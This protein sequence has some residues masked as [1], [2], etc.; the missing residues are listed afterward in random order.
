MIQTQRPAQVAVEPCVSRS[1]RGGRAA[2]IAKQAATIDLTLFQAGTG[3]RISEAL[4]IQKDLVAVVDGQ[5]FIN[6]TKEIAKTGV[7]RQVPVF[8]ARI[9]ARLEVLLSKAGAYLIGAPADPD[10]Q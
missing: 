8:D 7:A 4:Q 3:L 10:K 1:I 6:V 5:M 9:Q 2:T